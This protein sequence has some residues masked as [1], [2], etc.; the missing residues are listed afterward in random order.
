MRRFLDILNQ[1]KTNLPLCDFLLQVSK[2]EKY[3]K[4]MILRKKRL[5]KASTFTLVEEY[6]AIL[7]NKEKLPQILNDLGEFFFPLYDW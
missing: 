3:L 2:C 6:S 1:F 5:D 7:I 4:E